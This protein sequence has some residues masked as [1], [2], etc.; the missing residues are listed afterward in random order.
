MKISYGN[1]INVGLI[2]KQKSSTERSI[3][4]CKEILVKNDSTSKLAIIKLKS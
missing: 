3:L 1:T 2:I 4:A